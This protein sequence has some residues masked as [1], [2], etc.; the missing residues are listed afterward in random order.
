MDKKAVAKGF[1]WNVAF[2]VPAKL[3]FPIIGIVISRK[4]GTDA[5][6]V[7]FVIQALF[8][9]V[10]LL[11]DGGL[12]LTYIGDQN[13]TP[14]RE[15]TYAGTAVMSAFLFSVG[16]LIAS[17]FLAT[18]NRAPEMNSALL[19][20]AFAVAIGG[21]ITIPVNRLQRDAK[22]REAGF[23]DFVATGVGYVVALTLALLHFGLMSLI[24]Q[25]LVRVML[26]T[27]LVIRWSG[28][29]VPRF[30]VKDGLAIARQSAANL[31]SNLAYF[32]YTSFD[33]LL[34]TRVF[35]KQV[36]GAYGT[37]FG[38][39]SKPVELVTGPLG[40]T[41]L[42]AFSRASQEPDKQR[43]LVVRTLGAVALFVFP[44]YAIIG[45]F[46]H[47]LILWLYGKEFALGGGLLCILSLYLGSR[48]I[49]SLAGTALVSSGNAR[50]NAL[51]WIPGYAI[52]IA[53][54]VFVRD[55]KVEQYVWALTLGAIA[56][57]AT[58]VLAVIV[59]LKLNREQLGMLGGR[60]VAALPS[61]GIIVGTRLLPLPAWLQLTLA[62]VVGGLVQ[63]MMVGYMLAQ[64]PL[65][66]ARKGGLR[67]LLGLF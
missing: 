8:M 64:E 57:Y 55:P 16:L 24:I 60:A 12:G 20:I 46:G 10:E 5:L 38:F 19:Y 4:V 41:M 28:F 63:V 11:R 30:H 54:V 25:L 58:N 52:V 27:V 7:F 18:F 9:F 34:I 13:M 6:G 17:P 26:Y 35:G 32:V 29:V 66:A 40:R 21:F 65:L 3:I 23:A 33:Y 67:R 47:E 61:I 15:A 49:G 51:S 62:T 50:W 14:E 43:L 1:A 42:I 2:S 56:V 59:R 31:F 48:A 37:A 45:A 53:V 39:A 22:F 44:L 36:N